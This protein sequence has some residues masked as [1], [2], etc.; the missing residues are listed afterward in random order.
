MNVQEGGTS[1]NG[2][3][4]HKQWE[5]GGGLLK[6]RRKRRERP[7]TKIIEGGWKLS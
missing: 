6:D 1:F 4:Y 2:K 5:E 7:L 3:Y